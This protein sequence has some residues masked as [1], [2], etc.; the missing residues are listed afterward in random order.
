MTEI[1]STPEESTR[2]VHV[3]V[4]RAVSCTCGR[5]A[6]ICLVRGLDQESH[7]KA[8]L[9]RERVRTSRPDLKVVIEQTPPQEDEA[10]ARS[11]H[12]CVTLDLSLGDIDA[13]SL[14]FRWE[15]QSSARGRLLVLAPGL[16]ASLTSP[17]TRL[18]VR[19][20]DGALALETMH[21]G[22]DRAVRLATNPGPV[23]VYDL[24]AAHVLLRDEHLLGDA[25]AHTRL[26]L[27]ADGRV[28]RSA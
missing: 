19:H 21:D 14:N 12:R 20:D 16:R 9:L 11:T 18:T 24:D 15:P 26:V 5:N 23:D 8:Q 2:L 22:S 3:L 10:P 1:S 6:S 4:Q 25:P 13:A 28:R 27:G 7:D 17:R